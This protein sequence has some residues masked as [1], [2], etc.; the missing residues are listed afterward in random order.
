VIATELVKKF[1]FSL[2]ENVTIQPATAITLVPM[3]GEEK[4]RLPLLIERLQ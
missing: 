1:S 2:A 3:D 4:M